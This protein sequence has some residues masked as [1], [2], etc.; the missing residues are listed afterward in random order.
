M[1]FAYMDLLLTAM[2]GTH[3][4][5]GQSWFSITR[6]F[7]V[8]FLIALVAL[9]VITMVALLVK[10]DFFL[11]KQS[12]KTLGAL[13]EK[14]DKGTRYRV[15]QPA[16]FFVRRIM[17]AYMIMLSLNPNS[18]SAYVQFTVIITF[19]VLYVW[20]LLQFKPYVSGSINYY[21]L[22]L[23]ANYLTVAVMSYFFT[24]ATPSYGLKNVAFWVIAVLLILMVLI[25]IGF[26]IYFLILGPQ[27]IKS[28]FKEEQNLR[29]KAREERERLEREAEEKRKQRR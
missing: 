23:E 24:D 1:M 27:T 29:K 9:P 7:A 25:N 2:L 11:N 28:K 22:L 15:I 19:S 4:E 8:I 26:S 20:Y 16:F 14:I 18:Q 12:K 3:K 21:V 5:Q 17:T 6:L 10:F 13:L